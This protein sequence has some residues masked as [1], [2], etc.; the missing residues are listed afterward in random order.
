S[1]AV[2]ASFCAD[3]CRLQAG[4][5][6]ARITRAGGSVAVYTPEVVVRDLGTEFGVH[7]DSEGHTFLQVFEGKVEVAPANEALDNATERQTQV[8][9]A[10]ETLRVRR[11]VPVEVGGAL[12]HVFD[13]DLPAP[14]DLPVWEPLP[15]ANG[16]F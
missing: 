8:V 3:G 9:G 10:G 7:V 6:T 13:R 1:G 14:S 15:L 4:G 11:G 2:E 12:P 5:L 16:G